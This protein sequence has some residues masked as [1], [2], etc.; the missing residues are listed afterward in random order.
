[1]WGS[2]LKN[3]VGNLHIIGEYLHIIFYLV[4]L[5]LKLKSLGKK[6]K[7]GA[8]TFSLQ[9]DNDLKN[10]AIKSFFAQNKI[11]TLDWSF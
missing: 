7:L 2:M 11:S 8:T 9:H 6:L 10:K 4:I 1:M 3:G 5:K